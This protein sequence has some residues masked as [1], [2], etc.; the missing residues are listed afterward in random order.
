MGLGVLILNQPPG[1]WKGVRFG[2][3]FRFSL[4]ERLE[5]VTFCSSVH[6]A[7]ILHLSSK[8]CWIKGLVASHPNGVFRSSSL[9]MIWPG[10]L[11]TNILTFLLPSLSKRLS[12]KRL[13]RQHDLQ[14]DKGYE[15]QA[16]VWAES[17]QLKLRGCGA[18]ATKILYSFFMIKLTDIK[19]QRKTR[20]QT[21]FH[22]TC[23][24]TNG[25]DC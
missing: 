1:S 12:N 9:W 5:N 25:S 22:L 14:I 7:W 2:F 13:R 19:P 3:G 15:K 4:I 20:K 8:D 11:S 21:E 24:H 18:S 17:G 16:S 6:S 23:W 10:W